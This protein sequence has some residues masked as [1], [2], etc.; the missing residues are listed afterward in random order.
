V[1]DG[2]DPLE[3]PRISPTGLFPREPYEAEIWILTCRD[4]GGYANEHRI[5]LADLW[6]ARGN[7]GEPCRQRLLEA[8]VRD[9]VNWAGARVKLGHPTGKRINARNREPSV[10]E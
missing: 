3:A 6:S 2:S 9:V 4:G 1:Y 8:R 10:M 5:G 7:D